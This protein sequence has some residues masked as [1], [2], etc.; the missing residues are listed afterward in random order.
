MA[1][2]AGVVR[3]RVIILFVSA[4]LRDVL[5]NLLGDS[6]DIE[7]VRACR[8][9]EFDPALLEM[10]RPSAVVA[11]GMAPSAL[12]TLLNALGRLSPGARLVCLSFS[13]D[14]LIIYRAELRS[15]VSAQDLL[16]AVRGE[17]R[18]GCD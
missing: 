16:A 9:D 13:G 3:Q 12:P 5:T 18:T 1:A 11:D 10:D 2:P 14:D 7:I 6:Q 8:A 17:E 4:L 15:N